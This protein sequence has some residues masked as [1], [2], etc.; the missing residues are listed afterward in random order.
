MSTPKPQPA[1]NSWNRKLW[2][3][4]MRSESCRPDPIIIGT[5][6]HAVRPMQYPGEP[7]HPLLFYTRRRA[8]EWCAAKTVECARHSPDWRFRPVRV[9]E[10]LVPM[11]GGVK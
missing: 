11:E 2:A 7:T 3:V 9:R 5:S 1:M 6:W 10:M 8:R 4:L